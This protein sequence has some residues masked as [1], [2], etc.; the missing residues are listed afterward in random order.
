MP[1]GPAALSGKL[2]P[3]DRIVGVG[4][5]ASGPIL[6]VIGW[7]LDD[8]VD[9]IRGA[10]DTV[11]RLEILPDAAGPDGKHEMLTLDP[12]QGQLEEQA[13]K[14]SIIDVNDGRPRPDASA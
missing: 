1:G 12:Q 13:A 7:R 2:K 6:D 8:V 4:Q 10:K 3:G 9:K 11:V 14:K 5:G